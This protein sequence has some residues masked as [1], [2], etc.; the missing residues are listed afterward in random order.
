MF[1]FQRIIITKSKEP[2]TERGRSRRQ[3]FRPFWG[4]S[5]RRNEQ[6]RLYRMVFGCLGSFCCLF[7]TSL[8]FAIAWQHQWG[9][10]FVPTF[11]QF[12]QRRTQQGRWQEDAET[13]KSERKNDIYLVIPRIERIPFR[14]MLAGVSSLLLKKTAIVASIFSTEV[15][16]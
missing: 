7:R 9:N 4:S 11:S 12:I 1:F 14:I 2:K 8:M 10:R 15:S 6:R 5:V 16:W 3:L 13:R